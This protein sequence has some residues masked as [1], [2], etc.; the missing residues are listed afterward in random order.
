[1]KRARKEDAVERF[2]I[3]SRDVPGENEKVNKAQ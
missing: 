3:F 2:Q 1:L